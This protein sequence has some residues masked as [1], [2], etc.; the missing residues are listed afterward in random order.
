MM[1]RVF[2]MPASSAHTALQVLPSTYADRSRI[3]D[4]LLGSGIFNQLDA[5]TVDEMFLEAYQRPSDDN[6]Q[7]LSC[8]NGSQ[9]A[10]FACYGRESLT[11][12]TWDLFWI[13]VSSAARR[14][15]VGSALLREVMRCAA[16]EQVRLMVIYTSSTDKYAPARALYE[17]HG[18][19]RAA[20]ISDY[21][22]AGDDLLIYTQRISREE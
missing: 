2:V 3:R 11:Q 5:E 9:L 17:S 4:I 15:G 6:Y 18:F 14:M 13:C 8:W 12:G 10:G 16:Q 22:A 7:F 19:E 1:D 20:L 21:Y